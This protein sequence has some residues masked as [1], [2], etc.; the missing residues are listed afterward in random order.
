[1]TQVSS[2][3]A[4]IPAGPNDANALFLKVFSGT[5]LH[6][7]NTETIMKGLVRE[8]TITSGRSAQFPA[9]GSLKAEYHAP[10]DVILGQ[11]GVHGE[12]TITVNDK[13]IAS[14]FVSDFEEAMNHYETR[15]E[16]AHQLGDAM[17]Q[18]EDQH[19]LAMLTKAAV[20]GA[21]GAV[22]GMGAATEDK[23]GT[24]PT[25]STVIDALYA[26]AAYFDK[27]N[28]PKQ[29]RFCIVNPDIWWD[30]VQDGHFLNSD[31]GNSGNGSQ[32][33][34]GL[35]RGANL[36]VIPSN[37]LSL[38]FTADTLQGVQAGSAT[39]DYTVDGSD[40]VALVFQKQ[41]AGTVKLMGLRSE[42]EKQVNR[43]GTLIVNS[44]AIGHDTLRPECVRL[45]SAKAA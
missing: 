40:T 16:F 4:G 6:R 3:N 15:T 42:K 5:V 1:M 12:K 18:A 21:T 33:K 22:T 39:T 23:I 29:D 28:V 8:K 11:S 25:I 9:I 7:Y 24:A 31:F 45:I 34:G 17:A 27:T 14:V 30:L 38:N 13:L 43:Q 26:A 44:Q 37:N 36:R 2:T 35:L 32:A 19:L 20:D 10:G 41:A